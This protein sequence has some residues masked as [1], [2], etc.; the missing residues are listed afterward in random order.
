MVPRQMMGRLAETAGMLGLKRTP[1]QLSGLRAAEVALGPP[2]GAAAV[3]HPE[4]EVMLRTMRWLHLMV[5]CPGLVGTVHRSMA[6]H[7]G[8]WV[9]PTAAL[10]KAFERLGWR[11]ERNASALTGGH[12]PAVV[13]DEAFRGAVELEAVE[14]LSAGSTLFTDGSVAAQG[15]AAVVR[16]E[17]RTV[18]SA[19]V[20]CPRSSTHAELVAL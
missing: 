20:E 13:A 12:W 15:G 2:L 17:P 14:V 6:M 1:L 16:L 5:N 10:R 7:Q 19:H 4:L 18:L 11:L 3:R 8:R 9:E